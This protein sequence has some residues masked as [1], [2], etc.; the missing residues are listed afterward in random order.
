VR[1]EPSDSS[2]APLVPRPAPG[3]QG[4]LLLFPTTDFAVFFVVVCTASWLLRPWARAWKWMILG[5]SYVFY[6]WW[7]WRF[8]LLLGA[9]TILNQAGALLATRLG[10]QR[11]RRRALTATI[12]GNVALLAWFKYYGFLAVN[13]ANALHRLGL[14]SPLPILQVALPVGISFFTFMGISYAVDCYRGTI[15]PAT[16]LDTAVYLAFF[17]HLVA[18][19]IVRGSDLLPQLRRRRDPRRID[20]TRAGWLILAGLAKKVVVSSFLARAIVDPVFALP[21]R[22]SAAEV[23]VGIYAYAIQ[24]YADFSG[25]TD[26]AIGV[27]LLLGFRFPENFN[28][29]YT[30][31]SMRD[32]WHRWHMTLSSWLRDY[33]YIPLGGNRQGRWRT[34]RNI[35]VTMLLGG[36]W[37]GAGWTFAAWGA[38]N[39][40]ALALGS[41]R[42]DRRRAQRAAAAREVLRPADVHRGRDG[43]AT[44][45][46]TMAPA[47][48]TDVAAQA[49]PTPG[50]VWLARLAT[51]NFVCFGWV[52]F[53]AE[54]FH[55]ALTVLS[56]LAHPGPAP[57]VTPLVLLTVVV[58]LAS[59]YVP[60]DAVARMQRH[61]SD[62]G[63]PVQGAIL[64]S[65]LYV[66]TLLG[67]I[68]VA[69]F[70]YYRF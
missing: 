69:P 64:G 4:R 42:R 8:V 40:G 41:L 39:G 57:L 21:H 19:P 33:V 55:S 70:I 28:A 5:A 37:H 18:G 29:P 23:L 10:D 3:H 53:R 25:Y 20:A 52:L 59:Q 15:E 67:P 6:G 45:T 17:P 46:L 65:G 60:S 43:P 54:S 58:A 63:A 9:S 61:L 35:M 66:I 32:F 62:L 7:D 26:I 12:L 11:W 14:G 49:P 13:V 1:L 22:H 51:F 50:R 27:A 2:P 31:T 48:P 24:I 44:A 68:G 16:W 47:P 34:A 36:L 56:R 38:L 30:A